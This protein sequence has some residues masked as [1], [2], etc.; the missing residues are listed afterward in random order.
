MLKLT[1]PLDIV[2]VS[3]LNQACVK[4]YGRIQVDKLLHESRNFTILTFQ[5]AQYVEGAKPYWEV[6]RD[7][8]TSI[9]KNTNNY[10]F[11]QKSRSTAI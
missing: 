5:K 1:T 9:V 7:L 6:S 10:D 4:Q 11:N 2:D 3:S 8:Q